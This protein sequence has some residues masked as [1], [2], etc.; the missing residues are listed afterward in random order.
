MV[1]EEVVVVEMRMQDED[2]WGLW[3]S[4][5]RELR[6]SDAGGRPGWYEKGR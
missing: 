3:L 6:C 2:L 1:V 5:G 4:S